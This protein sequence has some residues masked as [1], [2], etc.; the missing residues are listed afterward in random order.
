MNLEDFYRVI[1]N[2][3]V[4]AQG[5]VDTVPDPLLVLDFSLCVETANRAFHEAFKVSQDETI[6]KHLYE[7]GNRQWDIPVLRHLLEDVIP[8]STAII[9]YEVT[10]DFP[11]IGRRT[12]LLTAH[13]LHH[14][15]NISRT[16]LL[17]MVDATERRKRETQHDLVRRASAPN[18]ES[19]CARPRDGAPNL[20]GGAFERGVP[21]CVPWPV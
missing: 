14:P 2:G 8:K 13:R 7:L 1:R 5:I 19:P 12:M 17:S 6:G 15:D 18:K 20:N 9:D 11:N 16:L 3:H 10:H 21:R 4:R